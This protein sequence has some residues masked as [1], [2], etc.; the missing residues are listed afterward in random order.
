MVATK[1]GKWYFSQHLSGEGWKSY[2]FHPLP[3]PHNLHHFIISN[4]SS[5]FKCMILKEKLAGKPLENYTICVPKG[6]NWIPLFINFEL[7]LVLYLS[8]NP[9]QIL[10]IFPPMASQ[11]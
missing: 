1:A 8:G 7:I 9:E 4:I 5:T 6:W 10:L 3:N 11:S 2:P